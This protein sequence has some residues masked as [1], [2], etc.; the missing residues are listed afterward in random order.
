MVKNMMK[1]ITP[2]GALSITTAIL[3]GIWLML[4]VLQD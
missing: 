3:C 2:L 4:Q 1:K